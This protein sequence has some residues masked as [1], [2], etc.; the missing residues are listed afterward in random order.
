MGHRRSLSLAVLMVALAATL[1]AGCCS[2]CSKCPFAKPQV[3]R[4]GAVIAIPTESI[5][6]YK[7]LHADT[8]PG[9]LK[10]ID[11]ANIHNY[12]IYLGE[13]APGEHYLFAY[14]EY[15]GRNYKADMAKIA[16]GQDHAGVVEAHRP[17]AK[18][19][20]D[21]E[22]GRVVGPVGGGVPSY[23]PGV[24]EERHQVATRLDHRHAREEHPRLHADARG[25]LARRPG[26]HRQGQHP[27]LLHLPGPDQARRV[28]A[29]QLLR[30]RRRR[31]QGRHGGHGRRGDQDL[32]DAT[33]T[34]SRSACPARPKASSGKTMEEVFH[35]N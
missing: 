4:H 34:R 26:G 33:P 11:K 35:T 13:V 29:V 2:K 30:V 18:A 20:A 12:S 19:P 7:Q 21:E 24:Q 3:Q 15:T 17:A 14:S 32:V 1:L 9:V 28:P 5:A 10:T 23:R 25:G 6:E 27:Q 31:L 16:E 8:W 22:G